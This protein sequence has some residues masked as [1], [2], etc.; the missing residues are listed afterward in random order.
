MANCLV[1]GGAG[2]IGSNLV[3]MLLEAGHRVVVVDNMS[4]DNEGFYWNDKAE[5]HAVDICDYE[6]IRPLFD[7]IDVVFHMAAESR[8]QPSILNPVET[9]QK[10]VVGTCVVLQVAREAKVKRVV[11][12]STSSIY[13]LNPA[14][15]VET[16]ER[17]CLNPYAVTKASGED[18]CALYTKLYGLETIILRYFNVYGERSPSFGQ[19]APV[20]GIFLRQ[21]KETGTLTIV[22]D[23]KQRRDFIHVKDVA[24]ANI[25]AGF[26]E[27]DKKYYGQVFNVGSGKNI[28]ILEIGY[29]ISKTKDF[30]F[31]PERPG[32]AKLT[33][34]NIEKIKNVLG[35]SPEIDVEGW[36]KSQSSDSSGPHT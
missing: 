33:L 23:G 26:N 30:V 20:I 4:A 24:S 15:N 12:S 29:I 32:E 22:G 25:A 11:Y 36:I 8:L 19:Y 2:F 18:L 5:N 10:N 3:D 34:A 28:S 1:T 27:I 21:L 31:L 14:P 7:G 35:W 13:G 9:A 16:Q 6:K 17:D